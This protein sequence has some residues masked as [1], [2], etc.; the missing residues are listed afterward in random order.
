M[1]TARPFA[2][3]LALAAALPAPAQERPREEDLFG[4]PPGPPAAA[5]PGEAA[6]RPAGD[7]PG[8]AEILSGKGADTAE[9]RLAGRLGESENPLQIGGQ[10]YLRAIGSA[11]QGDPPSRWSFSSPSLLDVF[12]DA[13]PSD[14]VRAY[15]LARTLYDPTQ[16]QG[17]SSLLTGAQAAQTVG[18]GSLQATAVTRVVLD[19]LWLS[20][21]LERRA[22]VTAGKQHV[23]W[24][25]GRLW[26][27]TD[28]LHVQRRDPLAVFDDRGGTAMARVHVPLGE[29]RGA[30][31]A[32][33]VLEPLAPRVKPLAFVPTEPA[34]PSSSELG[35]V[36]GA[37][38]AEVVLGNWE[39][40]ADAV[41]QRGMKPRFGFD[42]SGG[43]W[44]IDLRGELAVRT[45]SDVAALRPGDE[46]VT[47]P[48]E[49]FPPPLP[50]DPPV[51]I[52][53]PWQ[54]Y[55]PSGAWVQ[56]VGSADWSTKYS[57]EDTLTIG[58]EYFYNQAG[59]DDIA[60]YPYL[61]G[62]N[63]FRPFYLGRHYAAL[64]L[65]LPKPGSW[66]DTT[67]TLTGI[68]NLSDRS[69]VVRLDWSTTFL[70][71]LRVELFAQGHLGRR[72]GEFRLASDPIPVILPRGYPPS[73][74]DV[75][76]ALRLAL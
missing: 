56:A 6:P 4:A 38:R 67:I 68:A 70:T 12:L 27:P 17:A 48:P 23:K 42:V 46:K 41:A 11:A 51:Q 3:L 37:A 5:R 47:L 50:G 18:V 28:Y 58:V 75:G 34:P 13:R 2:V 26:N 54:R 45:G 21:D 53:I 8:E 57:D 32:A 61:I 72:G 66:N 7:R 33:A 19:Q 16:A 30:L 49:L 40:G 9:A 71:W 14:R 31:T 36:G 43:L 25:T 20:F 15:G 74:V 52:F 10:L 60:L 44:E 29:Q 1:P 76:V 39:L 22:F 62:W 65:L 55:Q 24:G 64:F 63:A 73:T 69:G 59:Y 35:A